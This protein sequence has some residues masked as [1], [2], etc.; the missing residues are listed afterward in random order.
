M[1]T[2]ERPLYAALLANAADGPSTVTWRTPSDLARMGIESMVA[3]REGSARSLSSR[4]S[5][6]LHGPAVLGNSAELADVGAITVSWQRAVAAVGASLEGVKSLRGR[7]PGDINRRCALILTSSPAAGSLVLNIAPKS[8]PLPEAEPNGQPAM[9]DAPRPLSDR[10]SETLIN[11]CEALGHAGP[12]DVD[13]AAA[14]LRDLGPRVASA[15]RGLASAV[16]NSQVNLDVA[17]EEPQTP[18]VRSTWT[19]AEADWVRNF[20]DGRDL[21]A[22]EDVVVGRARTVSDSE[23][24]LL[25]VDGETVRVDAS[26][27]EL[28][29]VRKVRPGDEVTLTVH[30]SQRQQPDGTVRVTRTA[31]SLDSVAQPES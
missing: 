9:I 2:D 14:N 17:W 19:T 1:A 31:V 12:E 7:I 15:L 16:A 28:Q 30:I 27:L 8:N 4:G 29:D 20:V 5:L 10:A 22:E 6:R 23:R 26:A 24:W 18:T 21:D 11:L 25:E 13:S 3:D